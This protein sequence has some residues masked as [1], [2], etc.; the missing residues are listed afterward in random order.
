M[1][2]PLAAPVVVMVCAM[3]EPEPA[4][5][6]LTPDCVTVQAKVVPPTLLLRL[7][8][9]VLPE[10]KVCEE[11]VT[12]ADGIGVTVIVTTIAAPAQPPAVGVMV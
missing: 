11:G 8:E 1:A 12:V 10:Q 5:A 9:L 2:V 3:V 7:K 4:E 6:P